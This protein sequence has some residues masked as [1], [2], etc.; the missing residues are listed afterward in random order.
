MQLKNLEI[1]V[2]LQMAMEVGLAV[3]LGFSLVKIRSLSRSLAAARTQEQQALMNMESLAVRVADL[4]THRAG[5]EE[6]LAQVNRQAGIWKSQLALMES[7][8]WAPERFSSPKD[9]GPS[10]R[11]EVESLA[12]QGFA[13]DDIA[14]HLGLNP[15]E[16]KVALDLLLP[17][18]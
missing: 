7:G 15:S 1:W 2:L 11:A 16:V 18:G 12:R 3:L 13:P 8:R 14:R 4:E 9:R 5:L 10:L 6:L 17:R